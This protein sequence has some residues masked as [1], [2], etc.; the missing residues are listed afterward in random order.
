MQLLETKLI[1]KFPYQLNLQL[2]IQF[3]RPV[4][5][6]SL[7]SCTQIGFQ[8][9]SANSKGC[10]PTTSNQ[11]YYK[12][13]NRCGRVQPL[14]S[15]CLLHEARYVSSLFLLT[16]HTPGALCYLCSTEEE[17]EVQEPNQQ[18]SSFPVLLVQEAP[19]SGLCLGSELARCRGAQ[20]RGPGS[21][22]G[23]PR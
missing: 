1:C 18:G 19:A 4:F 14:A 13:G 5:P 20:Y 17:T 11:N 8:L 21:S 6:D 16:T 7:P 9:H 22:R 23:Q 2:P 10:R 12:I 3:S 15:W